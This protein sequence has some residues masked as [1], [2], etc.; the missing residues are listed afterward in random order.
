MTL[1]THR[2]HMQCLL[3]MMVLPHIGAVST[4]LCVVQAV[5]RG[6]DSVK[7]VVEE[8]QMSGV[9]GP[10]LENFTCEPRVFTAVEVTAGNRCAPPS[11]QGRFYGLTTYIAVMYVLHN[12]RRSYTYLRPLISCLY[13]ESHPAGLLP[14]HRLFHVIVDTD[15][16]ASQILSIMNK[17]K[18]PGEVTFLPLN[19]LNPPDVDYPNAKNVGGLYI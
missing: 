15:R 4:T 7:R 11:L 8:K 6:L 18:L 9:Y 13:T 12:V 10:L 1:D 2:I 14:S 19:K 17:Q 5:N 3:V 16:T